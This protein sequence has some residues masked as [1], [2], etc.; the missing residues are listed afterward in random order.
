[1]D[2]LLVSNIVLWVGFVV[3]ALINL[4]LARQIGVLYERVAPAGALTGSCR[5]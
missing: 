1:M 5:S 4:A 3:L 2:L